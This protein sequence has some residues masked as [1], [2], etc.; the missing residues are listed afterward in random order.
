VSSWPT[1]IQ[2]IKE[3]VAAGNLQKVAPSVESATASL[4]AAGKHLDSACTLPYDGARNSLSA[5]LAS[6]CR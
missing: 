5:V 1:G 4:A 3:L 6:H 2:T